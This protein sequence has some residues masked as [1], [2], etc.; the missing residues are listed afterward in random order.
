MYIFTYLYIYIYIYRQLHAFATT[1]NILFSTSSRKFQRPQGLRKIRK[2]GRI[3]FL[4]CKTGRICFL[5]C[6]DDR[7]IPSPDCSPKMPLTESE[8][9][10]LNGWGVRGFGGRPRLNSGPQNHLNPTRFAFLI[11]FKRKNATKNLEIKGGGT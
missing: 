3:C 11:K 8:Y 4:E 6:W 2:T 5:E 9:L 1:S 10:S 7:R